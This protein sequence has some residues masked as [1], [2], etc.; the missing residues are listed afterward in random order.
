MH[1]AKHPSM[2][3]CSVYIT[4]HRNMYKL[5]NTVLCTR[6][7]IGHSKRTQGDYISREQPPTD[8]VIPLT[9]KRI[10]AERPSPNNI[11]RHLCGSNIKTMR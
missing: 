9:I 3:M 2:Y 6:L 4:Q 1:I 5:P 11:E 10:L 8:D 7:R